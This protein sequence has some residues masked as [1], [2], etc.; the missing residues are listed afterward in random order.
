MGTICRPVSGRLVRGGPRLVGQH[1]ANS[2]R[3]GRNGEALRTCCSSG[4]GPRPDLT[5]YERG[6]CRGARSDWSWASTGQREEDAASNQIT[7]TSRSWR[8]LTAALLGTVLDGRCH[9]A[10]SV[11]PP[12]GRDASPQTFGN[13]WNPQSSLLDSS[14]S[15]RCFSR[16][17]VAR[18]VGVGASSARSFPLAGRV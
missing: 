12:S 3:S 8:R 6:W 13:K 2:G 16:S 4:V 5:C 17:H 10:G 1:T 15:L 7:R 11:S 18:R 14:Q 9:G